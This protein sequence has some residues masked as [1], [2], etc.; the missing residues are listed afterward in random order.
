LLGK[1]GEVSKQ[2]A[3]AEEAG[4]VFGHQAIEI[5]EHDLCRCDRASTVSVTRVVRRVSLTVQIKRVTTHSEASARE[6]DADAE[7][8]RVQ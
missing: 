3:L 7:T 5:G 6:K 8:P 4:T 2:L 1:L